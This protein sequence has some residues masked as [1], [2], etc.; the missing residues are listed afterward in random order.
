ML[1]EKIDI[2]HSLAVSLNTDA[3]LIFNA[4][5]TEKMKPS[6]HVQKAKGL[7][8]KLRKSIEDSPFQNVTYGSADS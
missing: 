8:K 1:P 6:N 7:E 5:T 3:E 2:T 4:I